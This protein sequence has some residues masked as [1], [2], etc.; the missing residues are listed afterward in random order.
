MRAGRSQG[1]DWD[2]TAPRGPRCSLGPHPPR[3][4]SCCPGFRLAL[5]FHAV[6][7]ASF[8]IWRFEFENFTHVVVCGPG[9]FTPTSV[10]CLLRHMLTLPSIGGH[11]GSF[12]SRAKT[13]GAAG[14]VLVVSLGAIIPVGR[15]PRSGIAGSRACRWWAGT[16]CRGGG[17]ANFPA[18][19]FCPLLPLPPSHTHS[20]LSSH[21]AC[22]IWASTMPFHSTTPCPLLPPAGSPLCHTLGGWVA[23]SCPRVSLALVREDKGSIFSIFGS[24]LPNTVPGTWPS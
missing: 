18:H 13:K 3:Q 12:Q 16:A 8:T 5:P 21:Y 4:G 6:C 19:V 11:L 1:R 23:V 22:H 15:V 17:C 2:S 20:K 9:Q 10:Q 7:P 24:E 14:D